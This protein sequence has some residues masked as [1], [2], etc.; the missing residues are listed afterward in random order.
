[1]H[2][3]ADQAWNNYSFCS[4]AP[5]LE[6]ALGDQPMAGLDHQARRQAHRRD[7]RA[8][9][10]QLGITNKKRRPAEGGERAHRQVGHDDDA[11]PPGRGRPNGLERLGRIGLEAHRQHDVVGVE[12]AQLLRQHPALVVEEPG[13]TLEVQEPVEQVAGDRQAAPLRH[14]LDPPGGGEA[15]GRGLELRARRLGGE[16]VDRPVRRGG[17]AVERVAGGRLPI[18]PLRQPVR[19][20]R[21]LL[22]QPQAKQALH[23]AE[24][25]EAQGLGE[26]N[27]RRWMN[28][29]LLGDR[30][31]GLER[32]GVGMRQC[33]G[34]DVLEPRAQALVPSRDQLLQIGEA[35]RRCCGHLFDCRHIRSNRRRV[36][37][38]V[39]RLLIKLIECAFHKCKQMETTFRST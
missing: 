22:D 38:F 24:A 9:L 11:Q 17:Q 3:R 20:A 16:M 31:N 30:C 8:H 6:A 21:H 35:V 28:P 12:R 34:R 39:P 18:L 33:I 19:V 10:L 25:V 4:P 14:D 15:A 23:V 13:R 36:G 32:D 27:E 26:A 29:R 2:S 7:E 5:A 37:I 1:M